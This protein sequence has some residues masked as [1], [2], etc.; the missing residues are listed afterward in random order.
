MIL[1]SK[2]VAKIISQ[3]HGASMAVPAR[4]GAWR[5]I[6]RPANPHQS[7]PCEISRIRAPPSELPAGIS[8]VSKITITIDPVQ[9]TWSD[10]EDWSR[11]NA[12]AV[13]NAAIAAKIA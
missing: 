4:D 11:M 8:R 13:S 7:K 5:L 6:A 12:P 2:S 9:R 10:T 1:D 3:S